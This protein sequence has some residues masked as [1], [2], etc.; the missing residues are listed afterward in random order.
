MHLSGESEFEQIID[1]SAGYG[2]FIIAI[3]Q[4]IA[5][6]PSSILANSGLVFAGRLERPDD[7]TAVV[8][9]VGREERID[10]RDLV[11]WFPRSP[12]GWF[13]CKTSRNFDFKNS[14]PVLVKIAQLNINTPSNSELDEMLLM[15]E[16]EKEMHA[17][18]GR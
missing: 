11:K 16:A 5:D 17:Y 2:L 14:E 10:D 18:K 8:R 6:M 1:Q 9:A 15:K 13:V 3:T 12:I 4:K 7:V